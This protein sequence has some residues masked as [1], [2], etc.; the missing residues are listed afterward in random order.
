METRIYVVD[1]GAT[2]RLVRSSHPSRALAHVS[3]TTY[4]VRVASQDDLVGLLGSGVV[5]E[6]DAETSAPAPALAAD[7]LG[8]ANE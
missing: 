6:D 3:R 5:V 7:L 8:G 4:K 1:G 2:P